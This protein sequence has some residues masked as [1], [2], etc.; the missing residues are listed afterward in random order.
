MG[1]SRQIGNEKRTTS[2]E[3]NRKDRIVKAGEGQ[4]VTKTTHYSID[5]SSMIDERSYRN[6]KYARMREDARKHNWN[7]FKG[8]T[9][10]EYLDKATLKLHET[11]NGCDC[12]VDNNTNGP[13]NT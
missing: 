7:M 2:T 8:E 5:G 12:N 10:E 11:I 9:T 13:K 4:I 6:Y 3:K 1:T